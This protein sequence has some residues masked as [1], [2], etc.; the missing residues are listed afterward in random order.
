M[1]AYKD[2][3]H[4]YDHCV[5]MHILTAI[6]KTIH[7]LEDDLGL[8]RNS[9]L[10]KLTARLHNLSGSLLSKHTTLMGFTHQCI[11]AVFETMTTLSKRAKSRRP[12]LMPAMCKS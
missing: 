5:A 10:N 3:M 7:K 12:L 4:A 11:I 6:V 9:I 1:Q 2:P 8:P